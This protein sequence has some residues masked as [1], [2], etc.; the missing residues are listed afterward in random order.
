MNP[1][2]TRTLA[3]NGRPNTVAEAEIE[4]GGEMLRGTLVSVTVNG[5]LGGALIVRL[6]LGMMYGAGAAESMLPVIEK[7]P[8]DSPKGSPPVPPTTAPKD[9][10]TLTL[11][12]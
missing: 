11:T 1:G 9:P 7:L 2:D 10:L 8:P 5:A 3:A 12:G 6:M 4:A